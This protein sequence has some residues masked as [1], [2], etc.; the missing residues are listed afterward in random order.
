GGAYQE[1]GRV[2]G[3]KEIAILARTCAWMPHGFMSVSTSLGAGKALLRSLYEQYA[4]WGVDF[5]KH[6]YVFGDDLDLSE[7][8]YVSEVLR[9][10]DRSIVCSLSLGTSVTPAMA[11]DVIGLVIMYRITGDEWD[12]WWDV[13]GHFDVTRLLNNCS[14]SVWVL[15]LYHFILPFNNDASPSL[16][17]Q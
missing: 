6:D 14:I 15:A 8:S 9:K 10:L 2:W 1:S 13:K 17:I 12:T 3:A 16:A 4:S 5:V 7:I 11:K